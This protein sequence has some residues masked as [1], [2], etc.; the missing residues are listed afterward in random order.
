MNISSCFRFTSHRSRGICRHVGQWRLRHEIG[1]THGPTLVT[2]I[3]MA[4]HVHGIA[5][6]VNLI[7]RQVSCTT[8]F[9]NFSFQAILLIPGNGF[10][11]RRLFSLSIM[12]CDISLTFGQWDNEDRL[13]SPAQNPF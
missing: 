10:S 9:S 3:D 13:C 4:G 2:A 7:T 5:I 11:N 6:I 12:K 8:N 1:D